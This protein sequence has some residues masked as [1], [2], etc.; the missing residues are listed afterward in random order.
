MEVT[1]QLVPQQYNSDKEK[2]AEVTFIRSRKSTKIAMEKLKGIN[3][4]LDEWDEEDR[5]IGRKRRGKNE[6]IGSKKKCKNQKLEG[7][8][9]VEAGSDSGRYSMRQMKS[10]PRNRKRKDENGNEFESN[11]CHQC[12]R[13]DKGRVVRCT[14]CRTKRYCVPC[15]T[16]WYP[17][18]PEEAFVES[19]PVC[20]QICNCKACLRLDGPI[21]ALKNLGFEI[22]EEEKV[23]YSKF[24]LQKLLP[25]LRRI[26]TE[27]VME[28][29][30]EAK[31][32][33]L[34]VSN[35]K[36][37]KE[38]CH[39]NE[40]VYCD[41][42]QTSIV[43][44]HRNCSSCSYDLCL[45]CCRELRDGHL[46][47][48]EEVIIEFTDKGYA[49][50]HGDMTANNRTSRSRF[51][52]NK[53]DNN[54][55]GDA[56]FAYEMEPRDNGGLPPENSGGRA[57][58]WKSNVDSS[59][60]CP[61]ENFGGCGKGSLEL[62]C[63][64]SNSKNPV[65]ELLAKAEYIAKRC[66][67]EH[68]PQ[69]PQGSCLCI[70]LVDETDVQKSK[71]R[72]AASRDDSDDNYLYC[73]AAKDLQQEDLKHFQCHWL[74]GEPVIVSNVHETASG[75]SWEPM[76]MWRACRQMKNLKHPILLDVSAINSLDWCEL[77]INIHQ[78]FKGYMEGRFDSFGWPQ[79][80]KL[81][82]WPP[83]GLF[84][85]RLPR[86][87]AEFCS[88][89][90][91]K[92][93]T[94][95]Q[96]GYL[97]LALKLPDNC[98]KPDLGPKAYIAY[99][100][101]KELGRGDSV[102][103]LHYYVSD[104]V[105]LLMHTQAAVP[106]ADQLSAI[107]NL[108]QKHKAQDQKEF[109]TDAY[110][111]HGRI[112]D[113]VPS[114]NGKTV[115]NEL[116]ISQEKQNCDG[117][118]V[119]K[120]N[121]AEKK[122]YSQ[123]GVEADCET[124]GEADQF[125]N[126]E[127]ADG[128]ALW[129]VFRRKDIPELEEY[130]RK[131]FRE[132]RHIYGSPLPQVVHPIH[133]ETFYLSTEHKRRLKEEYGIEPW[134]FVQKLGEA[135][136]I[137]A[138]CPHQIRNLKSCINVAVD[139]VSPENV[140]ECIRLT[141]EFRQLPRNHVAR[142]DKLEVKKII[143]RAVSQ[144]VDHLEKTTLHTESGIVTGSSSSS[145]IS[146][147]INDMPT[148]SMRKSSSVLEDLSGKSAKREEYVAPT[149]DEKP[150]TAKVNLYSPLTNSVHLSSA[151]KAQ[152][153]IFV[154]SQKLEQS[155]LEDVEFHSVQSFTKS[156]PEQYSSTQSGQSSSILED[157]Y[158]GKTTKTKEYVVPTE[159][160]KPRTVK[161]DLYSPLPD[162]VYFSSANKVPKREEYVSLNEHEKPRTAEVHLH[163]P[164]PDFVHLS[165][166]NKVPKRE[167]YVALNED[168]K[169]RT[170]EFNLHSPLQDF[171]HLSSANKVPKREEYAAPSEDEKPRT[172]KFTPL[173][174]LV[175]LSSA[176]K[177]QE[178]TSVPCQKLK[179][180]NSEEVEFHSAR[181]FSKSLPEQYSGTESGLWS[182]NDSTRTLK[183]L[184]FDCSIRLSLEALADPGN[185]EEMCGAI[186]ALNEDPSSFSDKHGKQLVKLKHE[187]PIMVKKWRD[188]AQA[189]S[190]YQEFLTNFEKDKKKLDDWNRLEAKLMAEYVKKEEQARELEAALQTIKTR[191]KQIMDE[192]LEATREAQRI[193]LLAQEKVSKI[194][195]TKS[196]LATTKMEMDSLRKNWSN[197]QSSFP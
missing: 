24:I 178:S 154:P 62:K 69:I 35:L 173:P 47:G 65:S 36:L 108:K 132:F 94:H 73:P 80:L 114:V 171:A 134:T 18:M 137:P 66:E 4:Q 107:E 97:N 34:P 3:Q 17:G 168:E 57:G 128:G 112:K 139:F 59:I 158:S 25:L 140:N 100:F 89:L 186:A 60:P 72:K 9:I 10:N 22:S 156:L 43:D 148:P 131:H 14:N 85:E 1:E 26:N 53:V 135:I 155:N 113:W 151:S 109:A 110:R 79:L 195:R 161:V 61:P 172:A 129:D 5:N 46:K 194:D 102:T 193:V 101:P 162:F 182:N 78:F 50:L 166:A 28:M 87:G 124:N 170:A 90:P 183:K 160:E 42:C 176:D 64:L 147:S 117:L 138:G 16:R 136:F 29:E 86:H 7:E 157:L 52:K 74:K 27:Q 122:K 20:C 116:S 11:M 126:R 106:A 191:Q 146:E 175:H 30:V 40:R 39:R 142:E 104:T 130:L 98:L 118:E 55:V 19:C 91:F 21:R 83:S 159:D 141:E 167:E 76:V 68:M 174:D 32:Q 179:Q 75:L 56:E 153:S 152:E 23:Q 180:S 54:P 67:L 115:L 95:P 127:D 38:K 105:F 2:S 31:I 70:K 181:S 185:E 123:Q 77:E 82:D 177:A 192:R 71:L 51:S 81:N 37:Q 88:C 6:K 150:R 169:P 121:K 15:M 84:D 8:E 188:L 63:L 187:F 120:S 164:L 149:E 163:S 144:A 145:L 33:G 49:Y 125:Q 165:S 103:K 190:S 99:G 197:F 93:Y 189:E 48:G 184:I 45:T 92:E 111:T 196:K 133:D 44:F 41:N 58:E 143:V 12:Q 96:H 13:N 119:E